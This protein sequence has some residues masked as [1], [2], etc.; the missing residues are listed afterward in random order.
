MGKTKELINNIK[1]ELKYRYIKNMNPKNYESFLEKEYKKRTGQDLNIEHPKKYTEK[2]QYAKL[3]LNSP[4]KTKLSD[5]YLV[6]DWIEEKIGSQYLIPIF[7][8]WDNFSDINFDELP[9]RFVLKL[10]NG[11]DAN[12]IVQDK[13]KL[14]YE[15]AKEKFDR[16]TKINFGY[17]KDIQLH[18]KDIKPKI[19]AE[20]YIEDSNGNLPEFKFFCFH[21]KVYYCWFIM[22]ENGEEYRNIYD[23]DWN[24]QP[25]NINN[26]Y[27][28]YP[29][30][31]PKPKNFDKMV[32]IATQLCQGF[33]HVRVDLYNVDEKIY[34][35]EM[36]FTSG[37]GY[38]LIYPDKYN[39][40]LGD[41]WNLENNN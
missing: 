25:W 36:T 37:G 5:K 13:N 15:K 29:E 34:F 19:I 38:S 35:G 14:D 18:Y 28:N 10:N 20:K 31:L 24:L 23:L 8:A 40:I 4:L 9:N 32:K 11:S 7:G 21:G 22:S 41:L 33:S 39:Y 3:Y 6:R 12:I 30:P 1:T 16:W 2:I 26:I 27:S 17:Y